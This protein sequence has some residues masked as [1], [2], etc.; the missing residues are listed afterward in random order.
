MSGGDWDT[1]PGCT[2]DCILES[3]DGNLPVLGKYFV[4]V[5]EN[6]IKIKE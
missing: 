1:G 6:S 3:N 2:D 5:F 4:I